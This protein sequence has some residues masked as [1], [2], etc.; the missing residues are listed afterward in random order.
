MY[1]KLKHVGFKWLEL[2]TQHV[3]LAVHLLKKKGKRVKKQ[4]L[5]E[6]NIV[7]ARLDYAVLLSAQLR[8]EGILGLDFLINCEAE[9][10]FPEGRIM[11]TVNEEVFYFEFTHT[12][13]ASANRFCDLGLMSIHPQTQHPSTTVKKG[14]CYTKNFTPGGIEEPIQDRKRALARVWKTVSAC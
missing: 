7:S 9:I 10:S 5:L 13:E 11:L 3:N 1:N 8:T 4:V 6:I 2:P 12:Q 14:Q